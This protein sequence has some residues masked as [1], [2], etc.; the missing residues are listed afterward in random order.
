MLSEAPSRRRRTPPRKRRARRRR[1]HALVAV[2]G[3]VA[4][5]AAAW[6]AVLLLWPAPSIA[7]DDAALARVDVGPLGEDVVAAVG[8]DRDGAVGLRLVDGRLWPRQ[9]LPPGERVVVEVTVRR[10][11]PL[12]WI[13]GDSRRLRLV[14]RTP[15]AHVVD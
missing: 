3:A 2:L 11:G 9:R 5:C 1:R 10:R 7:E 6:L 8:A 13:L 12:G 15:E 14:L 4:L